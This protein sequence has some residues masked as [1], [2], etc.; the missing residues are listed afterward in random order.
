MSEEFR[1]GI[2]II[3]GLLLLYIPFFTYKLVTIPVRL[4]SE[5]RDRLKNYE[6]NSDEISK[7]VEKLSALQIS[8]GNHQENYASILMK[9]VGDLAVQGITIDA[10]ESHYNDPSNRN[11]ET[12]KLPTIYKGMTY[13]QL[14]EFLQRLRIEGVV[15]IQTRM[16]GEYM[17]YHNYQN[18]FQ[19]TEFGRQI[20]KRIEQI[21]ILAK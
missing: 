16:V 15:D 2:A 6:G 20:V 3:A 11:F 1:W 9:C 21:H 7:V 4:N 13:R 8:I 5:L 18:I 14:S 17:N 19:L 12:G 10:D